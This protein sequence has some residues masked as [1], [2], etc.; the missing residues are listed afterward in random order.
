MK[1]SESQRV[2]RSRARALVQST[3]TPPRNIPC[4]PSCYPA[5]HLIVSAIP[6]AGKIGGFVRIVAGAVL[7]ALIV[8]IVEETTN[9][10][11]KV[12]QNNGGR[13]L[14]RGS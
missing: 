3:R 1:N 9:F 5:A 14:L 10:G 12:I 8:A 6:E 11:D 2:K 7:F 4:C 13:R